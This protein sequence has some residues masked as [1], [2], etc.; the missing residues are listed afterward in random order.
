MSAETEAV[1][2]S[3][4]IRVALILFPAG[5]I[6]FSIIALF[7]YLN[8]QEEKQAR[9]IKYAAGLRQEL[10]A[11]RLT[12]YHE[13]MREAW[14]DPLK[15]ELVV[16]SYLNSTLGA[17]NM[18]YQTRVLREKDSPELPLEMIDLELTG[19][20]RPKDIVLVLGEY[21]DAYSTSLLLGIAH[22]ITGEARARTLRMALLRDAERLKLYYELYLGATE[23]VSHVILLGDMANEEDGRLREILHL[24]EAAAQLLRPQLQSGVRTPLQEAQA[25]KEEW[26]NLAERL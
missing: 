23:R 21:A 3:R 5:L 22:D 1:S 6:L 20:Q 17:E 26:L 25:L 14:K 2:S 9:S 13:I 19:K 4:W 16:S 15:G 11:E 24:P 7:I 10:N 18:G 8:Y 12:R